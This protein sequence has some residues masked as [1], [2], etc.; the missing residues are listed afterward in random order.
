MSCTVCYAASASKAGYRQYPRR[1]ATLN[2]ALELQARAEVKPAALT[3]GECM[4]GTT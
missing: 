1:D 2:P 4:G 3:A